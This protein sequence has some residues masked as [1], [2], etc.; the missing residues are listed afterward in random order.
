MAYL[1]GTDEAGYGPNL[2]PLVVSATLW[3]LPR[4]LLD[5]DLYD[6]LGDVVSAGATRGDVDR[7]AIADSKRLYQSG[8]SLAALERGLLSMLAV[9]GRRPGCWR[10]LIDALDPSCR[11]DLSALP[12]HDRFDV[13]LPVHADAAQID[14]AAMRMQAAMQRAGIQCRAIRSRV[15]FPN[16]FNQLIDELGNKSTLLT[17]VTLALVKQLLDPL[18]SQPVL[19]QCDKHGGRNKYGPMLQQAFPDHLVEVR[20]EGRE[21]S[22]YRW[23]PPQRRFE[24]RFQAKGER[25]LPSALASMASKYVRELAMRALNEFWCS[26][27]PD[28]KPTA[29]Y[30]ADAK[31]F[32]AAIQTTQAE[33]GIDDKVLWRVK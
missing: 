25:L 15:V 29:G 18:E 23:G 5:C 2:G 10:T 21:V 14:F 6:R 17:T 1:I 20:R 31:R 32:K 8:G 12:W 11:E 4:E 19:I 30:P 33:L 28:L 3:E 24:I 9:S 16:R 22:V 7:L 26:R 13:P 27:V